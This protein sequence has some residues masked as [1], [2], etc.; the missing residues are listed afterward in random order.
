MRSSFGPRPTRSFQP[1]HVGSFRL[2]SLLMLDAAAAT[3][4]PLIAPPAPAGGTTPP[5]SATLPP[6]PAPAADADNDAADNGEDKA[7]IDDA[8][9][10]YN[11]DL[12]N[13]KQDYI[14]YQNDV[15][16]WKLDRNNLNINVNGIK[17]DLRAWNNQYKPKRLTIKTSDEYNAATGQNEPKLAIEYDLTGIV[18]SLLPKAN[19]ELAALESRIATL[20]GVK[21][22]LDAR[23]ADLGKQGDDLKARKDK[24]DQ[25]KQQIINLE[26]GMQME[27]CMEGENVTFDNSDIAENPEDPSNLIMSV[28]MDRDAIDNTQQEDYYN[29]GYPGP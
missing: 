28:Y 9:K 1:G 11:Q 18:A 7:A 2:E 4:L 24:L 12:Q 27:E 5:D 6:G 21:K 25:Q 19:E 20:D 8:K 22:S 13:F 14:I 10:Q 23:K 3:V 17:D 15:N 26:Q 29:Y 16:G